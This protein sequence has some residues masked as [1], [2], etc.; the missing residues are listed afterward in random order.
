MKNTDHK[1]L[2]K[3]NLLGFGG[4]SFLTG[5]FAG[6][7]GYIPS[8]ITNHTLIYASAVGVFIMDVIPT[9]FNQLSTA[10]SESQVLVW[11][12]RAKKAV[13]A[14]EAGA[15]AG[16]AADRTLEILG[17]AETAEEVTA[18]L[19]KSFIIVLG[20]KATLTLLTT[21]EKM[22]NQG[23][24]LKTIRTVTIQGLLSLGQTGLLATSAA[25]ELA[26]NVA[27]GINAAISLV[28]AVDFGISGIWHSCQAS[29]TTDT[30][31]HPINDSFSV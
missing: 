9:L 17:Y 19:L 23:I 8:A 30:D 11:I 1:A 12:N 2:A 29:K 14:V 13:A 28:Q 15:L 5:L 24:D 18:K 16:V 3:K 20:A 10:E 25:G 6:F 27:S 31:Y 21:L 7:S 4:K 26:L 22:V